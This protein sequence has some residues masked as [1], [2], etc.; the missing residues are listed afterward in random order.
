MSPEPADRKV[1]ATGAGCPINQNKHRRY[2]R[3]LHHILKL[4]VSRIRRFDLGRN[5]RHGFEETQE[6]AALHR[7]I[8]ILRQRPARRQRR[9][10]I[11]FG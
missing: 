8:D 9:D 3:L 4:P 6:K 10:C 5:I 7:V 2:L 11:Q 1:C